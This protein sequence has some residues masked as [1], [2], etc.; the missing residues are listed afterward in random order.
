[1]VDEFRSIVCYCFFL[2]GTDD[3]LS[4]FFKKKNKQGS[5]MLSLPQACVP[6]FF[7]KK[8]LGTLAI[9]VCVHKLLFIAQCWVFFEF[10]LFYPLI[11][12]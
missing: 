1:M 2:I 6:E 4:T 10:F 3:M 12:S 8:G 5:L 11:F 9:Q 7:F